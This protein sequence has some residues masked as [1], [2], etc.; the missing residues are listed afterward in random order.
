MG[1]LAVAQQNSQAAQDFVA[2]K[3]PGFAHGVD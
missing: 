1:R 3:R 2:A